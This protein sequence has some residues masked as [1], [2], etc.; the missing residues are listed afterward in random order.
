YRNR[1]ID[2]VCLSFAGLEL[3]SPRVYFAFKTQGM[4]RDIGPPCACVARGLGNSCV[5]AAHG[6]QTRFASPRTPIVYALIAQP[7]RLSFACGIHPEKPRPALG[8]APFEPSRTENPR[9]DRI[10]LPV[11]R[12]MVRYDFLCN[13]ASAFSIAWRTAFSSPGTYPIQSPRITPPG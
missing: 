11:P 3:G 4:L 8:V 10:E 9:S 12:S 6:R 7:D 1:A 13:S 5:T 2:H